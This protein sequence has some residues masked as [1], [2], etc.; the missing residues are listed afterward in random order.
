MLQAGWQDQP[1]YDRAS[2]P[3]F[4][5]PLALATQALA[6]ND[7]PQKKKS[8][9]NCS[10][11]KAGAVLGGIDLVAYHD[12]AAASNADPTSVAHNAST[13][14][15][16]SKSSSIANSWSMSKSKSSRKSKSKS[17]SKPTSKSKSKSKSISEPTARRMT[18]TTAAAAVE[19][20][21][22]Q[23]M[24]V[25][26]NAA[27]SASING[28]LFYFSS[29]E[30]LA[31]FRAGPP[32]RF[33][34]AWGGL[35]SWGIAE[36]YW[37]HPGNLGPPADPDVWALINGSLHLFASCT[38]YNRFLFGKNLALF[39]SSGDPNFHPLSTTHC[40]LL[41]FVDDFLAHIYPLT[42]SSSRPK[43]MLA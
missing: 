30:N 38:H 9:P 14:V 15:D 16:P 19:P 3:A 24:A 1:P 41:L 43:R 22:S 40:R 6:D 42:I 23:M 18:T 34:P 25:P 12:L 27:Y 28:S 8:G 36:E 37:W 31:R 13:A 21:L 20:A 10:D 29:A 35:D 32:A 2:S 7:G 11:R 5:D 33:L 17:K 26:G 39:P 4:Y